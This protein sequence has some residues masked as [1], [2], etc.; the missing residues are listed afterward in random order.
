M[1]AGRTAETHRSK[2]VGRR[3]A[4]SLDRGAFL[5]ETGCARSRPIVDNAGGLAG[6]L[7]SYSTQGCG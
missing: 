1:V 5:V 4:L 3:H 6:S 2:K 7:W